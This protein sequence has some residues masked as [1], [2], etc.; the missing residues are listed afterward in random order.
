MEKNTMKILFTIL[1]FFSVR[2]Q[3][4]EVGLI[5]L[6]HLFQRLQSG[7]DTAY[8]VNFW[9][10]WCLPCIEELPH[11]E[12]LADQLSTEKLKVLLVSVDYRSQYE[13]TVKSFV[14]NKGF[15][16]EVFL[17]NETDPQEYINRIDPSW[18]GAIP[19]TIFFYQGRRKFFEG[20]FTYDELLT[21]YKKMKL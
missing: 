11:F 9:A 5:K 16:N 15:K 1:I 19:A 14:R 8:I 3:S 4:Q 12:K 18:S 10:T 6:D 17:L 20:E 7:K 21:Q 2:V 13:T